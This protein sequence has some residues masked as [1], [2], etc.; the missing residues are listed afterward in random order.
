[1]IVKAMVQSIA[2]Y[3]CEPRAARQK[4]LKILEA[5]EMCGFGQEWEVIG[6]LERMANGEVYTSKGR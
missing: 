6:Y 3:G 2:L 4:D 1:M 5:F